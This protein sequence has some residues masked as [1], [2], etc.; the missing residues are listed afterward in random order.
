LAHSKGNKLADITRDHTVTA[1]SK[2]SKI[3]GND[4]SRLKLGHFYFLESKIT[5]CPNSPIKPESRL[6]F[7]V[8]MKRGQEVRSGNFWIWSLTSA[9]GMTICLSRISEDIV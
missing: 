3:Q 5:N 8:A 2:I 1:S 6:F 7:L 9:S 4:Q